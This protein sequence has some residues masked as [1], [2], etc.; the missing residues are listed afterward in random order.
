MFTVQLT[1]CS[2]Y[3]F[4]LV[5]SSV[6]L[7]SASLALH[8]RVYRLQM[9]RIRT[10]GQSDVLVR[11]SVQ[12]LDVRSEMVLY[13]TGTLQLRY[14]EFRD[15]ITSLITIGSQETT[16][17]QFGLIRCYLLFVA[18]NLFQA[19]INVSRILSIFPHSFTN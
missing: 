13:V 18:K 17:T 11:N 12:T 19:A 1:T 9:G 6:E 4:A 2:I 7:L 3:L 5:I 10:D 14:V 8:H 16:K 15:R